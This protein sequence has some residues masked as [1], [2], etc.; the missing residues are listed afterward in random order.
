MGDRDR[1][2]DRDRNQGSGS[3][4]GRD[5]IRSRFEKIAGKS[6]SSS[7]PARNQKTKL[8]TEEETLQYLKRQLI[9][10]KSDTSN[11]PQYKKNNIDIGA[12]VLNGIATQQQIKT[13]IKSLELNKY[14]ARGETNEYF[15]TNNIDLLEKILEFLETREESKEKK[16][17]FETDQIKA[18]YQY[19]LATG[20]NTV[21]LPKPTNNNLYNTEPIKQG[22]QYTF[23]YLVSDTIF[24]RYKHPHAYLDGE[25]KGK[26]ENTR[27][28]VTKIPSVDFINVC[29]EI[30]KKAKELN[31]TLR[32][33]DYENVFFKICEKLINKKYPYV[34]PEDTRDAA[35]KLRTHISNY[36]EIKVRILKI[37][38]SKYREKINRLPIIIM[39]NHRSP[40]FEANREIIKLYPIGKTSILSVYYDTVSKSI[41]VEIKK[42]LGDTTPNETDDVI[43]LLIYNYF[44][45]QHNK[46][47]KILSLDNYAWAGMRDNNFEPYGIE[48][49][50]NVMVERFDESPTCKGFLV[51]FFNDNPHLVVQGGGSMNT[52]LLKGS[53]TK[54]NKLNKVNKT[55][56]NKKNT[57]SKNKYSKSKTT[58]NKKMKKSGNRNKSKKNVRNK[59]NKFNKLNKV[60]K[61]KKNKKCN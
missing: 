21:D 9:N 44:V 37:I 18:I 20:L 26:I 42:D 17:I 14:F 1:N 15:N 38:S 4:R 22:G 8:R 31:K 25:T 51:E 43:L 11:L 34:T 35:K 53:K 23:F 57:K 61:T 12:D 49:I 7:K 52:K 24:V 55:K 16:R 2:R 47:H 39:Y 58:K 5:S 46:L 29:E 45:I 54:K 41:Y 40:D 32:F 56:K 30:N 27:Y 36:S 50:L 19:K 48:E 13:V 10:E 59:F 33:V 3:N 60:N 6:S 28:L